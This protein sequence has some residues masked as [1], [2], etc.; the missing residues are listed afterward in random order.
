[1]RRNCATNNGIGM[2]IPI[3][4]L[5]KVRH[6]MLK[7]PFKSVIAR[8]AIVALALSLVFPFIPA[9]LAQS[10]TAMAEDYAENGTGPVATFFASDAD[11]EAI[12]WS[13][14]ESADHELFE[15][16]ADED[17]NGVLSF[18][19]SPD[20]EAPQDVGGE[21]TGDNIYEVT[22]V[23][24]DGTLQ[25]F[26]TV[27]DLEEDGE[28]SVDRP[29]PQV[30]IQ[31][32]AQLDDDDG[33]INST[34]WQW[35]KST[36]KETW[37]DI[38]GANSRSY[39]PAEEDEDS[40]LRAM[41]TYND[42]RGDDKTASVMTENAVEAETPANA[43]PA[44]PEED[45]DEDGTEEDGSSTTPFLRSVDENT[46]EGMA[47]GNPVAANDA[48]D[49]IVLYEHGGAD[50]ASFDI[51]ERTGQ[52]K[53]V[54]GLDYEDTN[55]TDHEY[56]VTVT[57]TD[58]S[59]ATSTV[60]VTIS[61]MDLNEAPTFAEYAPNLTTPQNNNPT[62]LTVVE[63]T[64][65]LDRD[66]VTAGV[67]Q[68][69]YVA[70]DEDSLPPASG[71]VDVDDTVTL[72][73]AG[74]DKDK[75]TLTA[76]ALAFAT[77]HT[78]DY[79]DQSEYSITIVAKDANAEALNRI[80]ATKSLDVTIEVTNVEETGNVTL[81]QIQLQVGVPV[82]AEVDDPDGGEIG[83][84][85][86]WYRGIVL[87]AGVPA[88]TT[89]CSAQTVTDPCSID[90]AMSA[91]Y[92][93]TSDDN[94]NE[95]VSGV[96]TYKDALS[97]A[98]ESAHITS[99]TPVEP[100][101]TENQ[102][103]EFSEEDADVDGT[104]EDGSADAP[105]LRDVDENEEDEFGS[106][107]GVDDDDT[108]LIWTISGPDSG[109]FDIGRTTGQLSTTE[110]LDFE[111]KSS[112][113]I[114]VTVTDPSLASGTA[115]VMIMVN[116][117]D[118]PA[119][120]TEITPEDYAENG[121]GPVATFFASDADGEAIEWSLEESA[122][123]ELFEVNADE[124]GNG[125]L[126]FKASPD[127]EAP[128]DVGGEFTGDNIYEVTVVANDGT[129]Q[130][131]VTVTDLEEDGEVSVDRLQPQVEIQVTAKLDD[132]DGGI[133][134]TTW[135][136][137]KST[138][139]ETWTDI[140]G[141]NSRS[142]TPAEEDEDSYLR[143]M[144]T[145]NDRR[146]DDKTASVMTENAVEAETPANAAPAFPEE[147][148]DENGTEEDG[149][150]T[151]PFLR[152]VD[153]NT[154]EGMA[155]GSPVAANDADDDIVLY[156]HGGADAASFDIDERTGQI[157]TVDGL[158]Y[159]DTNNTDHEY[160][161]TVTGTDPSLATSTVT[162]TISVMDLNEAPK[163]TTN[164]S[165]T[166]WTVVEK[167][168]TLVASG[169][170][171][172]ATT[173]YA[174]TDEDSITPAGGTAVADSVIL[175][176]AG[177]DEEKFT[178]TAGALA[179]ATTHTPD[180]EDQSEYSIT[181]V[182]KDAN[183][184][185]LNRI[186]A[187]K[188]LDVTIN[189]TNLEETGNVT[190]SQIQL[191]VGVPV[192]AEVDDPDGG[193]IGVRWQWYRGIVLAAG[194]PAS[195]TV[196]SAQTVTD[197]CSIDGAMSATYTPTS[198]DNGEIVSGVAT[199]KDALSD[200][201]ESAHITSVT[202]VE[203]KT[204]ENQAP[205]FSEEDADVDGTEEDGSADAPFLRDVDEG[206]ETS[207]GNPLGVDDDDTA[208]IWT[209]S[210]PDSG[211]FDIGRTTGQLSTTEE[212][213]FETKSSYMIEV[214]VTDPSLASGTAM[215]MIMVN[216]TDDEAVISLTPPTPPI[217]PME[218]SVTLS[219]D[220]PAVGEAI[221]ATLEDSNEETNVTWQWSNHSPG[222]EDWADIEGATDASYT[223]TNADHGKHVR[224]TA[225]YD[226]DS[227][228]GQ[229]AMAATANLVNNAPAFDA[230]TASLN[231]DE[232]TTAGSNVGDPV[233]AT[234]VNEEDLTYKLSG[235]DAA[236]FEI[237]PSGQIT[238]AEGASLDYETKTSYS[239]TVTATD[240]AGASDSID[241]T[242]AVNDAGLSNAYDSDDSGDINKDEAVQAV[243][244]YFTDT[245]TRGEVLE[246]LQLYFAG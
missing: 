43:A 242:I 93:P 48:D 27:T 126:S 65:D 214:T 5:Y 40:Y 83:V 172:P 177:P 194:V 31:V 135:Q 53:T 69:D 154:E 19:A 18:K 119:V 218:G 174:A 160:T 231:A 97:D 178:L 197:P 216:D 163:F 157:K 128:Q 137:A 95:I 239:V 35:A 17:G 168:T 167:G 10:G 15:V 180:Y 108:A 156:T 84:R 188:S 155:I 212:L 237:W 222:D 60:T 21:F 68:A 139:K 123:H 12:E 206:I 224:A 89:V 100:K 184:E 52:I 189:V 26:V 143:A 122:D 77:T 62:A 196:C 38:E 39:T 2:V 71:T 146:G 16:N 28:V 14:E 183:A 246:I 204:T 191:Q 67:Q 236:S 58:P 203:P 228:E 241:V 22:V 106:P 73:I 57:G 201:S 162:V 129:L 42:R 182:A 186:P 50:A 25:V 6:L 164:T 61:V 7:R 133:N 49:D 195:T 176:I 245:I 34:T 169:E 117:V 171:I 46:E 51:D 211:S 173:T 74:P 210:G 152:S 59:L 225:S 187:T 9:A 190:L 11:G 32:T 66:A 125:V 64:T 202:P 140:E 141:A 91:T 76:G 107:Q 63:G 80:P 113:M 99:V 179:F 151:K 205:E 92:T 116:D 103:P 121:T 209:I 219:T 150:S 105:F 30:E 234:D 142:Y 243:Q 56:T 136:W 185:A 158:D 138:D 170:N 4:R 8:I 87:A 111:T 72:T 208:L 127:F 192:T 118:D 85:W 175:T 101:T 159:E 23:A 132:D 198:D 130:V 166:E 215:M 115:M 120:I 193:E 221:T 94:G 36:D 44:F 149:S 227:G 20:F 82:T 244:D 145:Y 230:E 81:S 24:N 70:T 55:N 144:A 165:P 147:D 13:L 110:E 200:A 199:Y 148:S 75:F 217:V 90:G 86:Q 161:V 207:F 226:D 102:A 45:S 54:D 88:S 233:A 29:Q 181:I 37:T 134:S 213:D 98:S 41:A 220:S 96:A 112:Y 114:E 78:P 235:D 79:E 238:V 232:N 1:M 109:S 47:I 124:D 3:P 240:A 104:E 153:E 33:G 223:P 131:F 229:S